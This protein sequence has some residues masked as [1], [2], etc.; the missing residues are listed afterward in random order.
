MLANEKDKDLVSNLEQRIDEMQS[1]GDAELGT[2]SRL[3]WLILILIS[4]VIPVI[5]VVAAR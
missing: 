2:F 4:I 5:V 3:D 1:T